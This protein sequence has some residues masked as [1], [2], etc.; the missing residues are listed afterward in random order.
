M[1]FSGNIFTVDMLDFFLMK[2][3]LV[4]SCC[5]NSIHFVDIDDCAE[6]PCKNF[7]TC[8]DLVNDY[9]CTCADGWAGKNCD[10][11]KPYQYIFFLHL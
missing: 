4:T 11:S 3:K 7:A 5:L 6:H 8:Y 10:I 1:S 9:N 2:R